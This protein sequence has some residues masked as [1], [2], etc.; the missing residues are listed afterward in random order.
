[1]KK[2]VTLFTDS[3]RE[4]KKVRTLTMCGLFAALA[5]V[6][7]SFSI[8]LGPSLKIGF[9]GVPN[10]IVDFMF[11]PVTGAIFSGTMDILKLIVKPTGP[12]IPGL[13]LDAFL[14]GLIYGVFM[15]KK[16]IRLWRIAAAKLVV[17]VVINVCLAT[18]WLAQVQGAGFLATLPNRVIKNIV[19]WPINTLVTF[20]VLKLLERA[21]IFRSFG[22][23]QTSGKAKEQAI[24]DKA[25]ED[26]TSEDN[27]FEQ[28]D[29]R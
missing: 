19:M 6:I 10:E 5:F 8:Q 4:F 21:G 3:A 28:I 27:A 15:Y 12:W 14:A 24:K 13:T 17:T 1:M 20:L 18:Y 11:G 7:D 25:M 29:M 23:Y 9:S 26:M 16:P 2:F 22:I